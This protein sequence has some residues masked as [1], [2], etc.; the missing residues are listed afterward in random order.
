MDIF[1]SSSS[2]CHVHFSESVTIAILSC[3][4]LP[5]EHVCIYSH[6]QIH[7]HRGYVCEYMYDYYCAPYSFD[8]MSLRS[9]G[10]TY[11]TTIFSKYGSDK[12]T[13]GRTKAQSIIIYCPSESPTSLAWPLEQPNDVIVVVWCHTRWKQRLPLLRGGCIFKGSFF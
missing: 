4:K 1:R 3:R 6:I 7:K 11:H 13:W 9:T 2:P 5:I 12:R 8:C 10:L